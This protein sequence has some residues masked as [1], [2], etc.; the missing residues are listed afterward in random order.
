MATSGDLVHDDNDVFDKT[1]GLSVDSMLGDHSSD[2]Y[3]PDTSVC[4]SEGKKNSI[5]FFLK[6]YIF[7]LVMIPLK[8]GYFL[9]PN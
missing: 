7:I 5:F 4:S 2:D 3:I 1:D 6:C 9:E 8:S